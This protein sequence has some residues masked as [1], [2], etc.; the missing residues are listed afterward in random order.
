MKNL[1]FFF[2]H[3]LANE[4]LYLGVATLYELLPE[5]SGRPAFKTT[6]YVALA[7]N[8]TMCFVLFAFFH[9]LYMDFAQPVAYQM[10]GQIASYLA[11]LPAVSITIF[12]VLVLFFKNKVNWNLTNVL[13]FTGVCGW[14]V[15]GMGAV[16]DATIYNNFVL[17]NTLW[18]PAHFHSYNAM[19]NVLFSLA[20]FYW[21]SLQISKEVEP[22]KVSKF[23][24]W[25][26]LIGGSGFL[27]AFYI[28]GAYSVPRRY[29]I[30]PEDMNLGKSLA[31]WGALFATVYLLGILAIKVKIVKR[32]LKAFSSN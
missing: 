32:C 1:T 15:G 18:V 20:F 16:L 30:Y 8:A 10:I 13:Y 5:V 3:T 28:S 27:I 4:M 19:G 29:A 21:V 31:S 25:T 9:H 7:W 11:S 2:G 14:A 17:H 26:L 22:E 24:M 12:S 23:I 6:W